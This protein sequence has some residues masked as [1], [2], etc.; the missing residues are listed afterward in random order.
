M[1]TPLLFFFYIKP[2]NIK[3]DTKEM[4]GFHPLDTEFYSYS[5][6]GANE[7]LN[8]TSTLNVNTLSFTKQKPL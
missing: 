1:H 5:P 3:C 8:L 7:V 4:V 6:Q 2:F